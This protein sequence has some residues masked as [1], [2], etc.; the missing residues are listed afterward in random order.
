MEQPNPKE[1]SEYRLGAQK[2]CGTLLKVFQISTASDCGE[3]VVHFYRELEILCVR[4]H[5]ESFNFCL[6][7]HVLYF[8]LSIKCDDTKT[9]RMEYMAGTA[10]NAED[11]FYFRVFPMVIWNPKRL[12]F[13]K[14]TRVAKNR[15]VELCVE[16]LLVP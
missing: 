14:F 11:T 7:S 4:K 2:K 13:V 5:T 3:W 10:L 16:S 8:L 9:T 12:G 1:R 15:L 6:S